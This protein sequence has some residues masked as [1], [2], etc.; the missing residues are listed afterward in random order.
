MDF[1]NHRE[2]G[3][4]FYQK[5][6]DKAVE[7]TLNSKEEHFCLDFVQEFDHHVPEGVKYQGQKMIL[8]K[9]CALALPA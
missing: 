9:L 3:G 2:G 4:L 5:S 7:V 8:Y 1:L 6:L